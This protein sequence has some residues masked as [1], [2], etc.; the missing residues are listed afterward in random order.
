[1][2]CDSTRQQPDHK[3]GPTLEVNLH[4]KGSMRPTCHISVFYFEFLSL[5]FV[6][7]FSFTPNP[8]EESTC[9]SNCYSH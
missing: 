3:K 1:M 6:F 5:V 9:E 8:P 4:F 7:S 2:L